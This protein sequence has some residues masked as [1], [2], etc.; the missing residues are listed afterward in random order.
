MSNNGNTFL[1][2]L[3]GGAIGI[4]LGILF[5]PDKGSKTRKKVIDE[6]VLAKNDI[7]DNIESTIDKASLEEQ[8]DSILSNASYK[9]DDIIINLEKK[10]ALL[11][12]RNKAYLDKTDQ[13]QN[14]N[15]DIA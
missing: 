15:K 6:A 11:K 1:G 10:L 8:L 9:V 2:L 14:T 3:A 4:A 13:K 7:L 12:K 5:A